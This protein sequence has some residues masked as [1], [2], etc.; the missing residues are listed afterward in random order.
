VHAALR[1]RLPP[2]VHR[3]LLTSAQRLQRAQDSLALLD[4]RLV[5]QRGYAYLTDS[6][7]RAVTRVA[8]A[9]PG[10]EVQ[11]TLA[12]GVLPLRVREPGT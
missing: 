5:L 11:A 6:K 7:G 3:G 1:S 4:P 10:A 9:L 8:Q 12:D 2:A